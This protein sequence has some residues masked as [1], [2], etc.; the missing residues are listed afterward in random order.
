MQFLLP[1]NIISV[2]LP[3]FLVAL[4]RSFDAL[5]TCYLVEIKIFST[6]AWLS[7]VTSTGL[8]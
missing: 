3:T 2:V 5:L 4:L 1:R 8:L 6:E 7:C